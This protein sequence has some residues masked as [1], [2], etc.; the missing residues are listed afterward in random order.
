MRWP[1]TAGEFGG[2]LSPQWVKGRAFVGVSREAKSPRSSWNLT[3]NE[4]NLLMQNASRDL[5]GIS[6]NLLEIF[7]KWTKLF[8]NLSFTKLI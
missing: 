1:F 5:D 4:L 2:H 6:F 3:I 7:Q 8:L